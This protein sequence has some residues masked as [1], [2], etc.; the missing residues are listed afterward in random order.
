METSTQSNPPLTRM[1]QLLREGQILTA[2]LTSELMEEEVV[3][4][5]PIFEPTPLVFS[6]QPDCFFEGEGQM[7]YRGQDSAKKRLDLH[8]KA[9]GP[10]DRFKALITGPAGTGKTT[11]VR[12]IAS[13]LQSR[14]AALSLPTGQYF[15]L[16]PPQVKEKEL[17]D[18]FMATVAENP[19]AIVFID[20]VHTLAN[21]ESF[22][23]VLHDSGQLRYPLATGAWL[24]IPPTISW[25]AATTNPGSLDT[26]VGGA[27]RRRLEPEIR[28]EAPTKDV[29][30]QIVTDAAKAD[31]FTIHPDAAF[32][33]A[34]RS[35]FPWQAKLIY[36]EARRVATVAGSSNIDPQ[37][38][39]ETFDIM[40]IDENGLLPEDRDVLY[41]LLQAPYELTSKKGTVRYR[42]SEEALCSSAGVDRQTYKQ[43]IQSKLLRQGLLT[44]VGGQ[45][46]TQ[47][48]VTTYG[49]LKDV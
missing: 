17:L 13:R 14:R 27:M 24:D 39:V 8:T 12:I 15:E 34:E 44:T 11:L 10:N 26:T 21:L 25:M 28:L 36:G 5:S 32:E 49:W 20:E 9:L 47:K 3:E 40:Q 48:A 4:E 23:H 35:L 16:L 31:G 2:L 38:T 19:Y 42:M 45:S 18:L 33:I 43:R 6:G 30:A 46:L 37:H 29:L 1:Q 7:P 41:A 22:F